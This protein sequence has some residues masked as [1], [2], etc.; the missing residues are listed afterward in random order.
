MWFP[1]VLLSNMARSIPADDNSCM[2][3]WF[4]RIFVRQVRDVM[5][6]VLL[7]SSFRITVELQRGL[8]SLILLSNLLAA[9]VFTSVFLHVPVKHEI[10]KI[11]QRINLN[12]SK[13]WY[14]DKQGEH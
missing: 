5:A 11:I 9:S 14:I 4:T 2:Q 7:H 12:G 8:F 10:K 1:S 3:C 13:L 6:W